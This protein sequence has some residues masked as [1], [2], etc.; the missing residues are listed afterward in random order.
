MPGIKTP[1]TVKDN[2]YFKFSNAESYKDLTIKKNQL[3]KDLINL[4]NS[5]IWNL[6]EKAE[7][8]D[9]KTKLNTIIIL[10]VSL[11]VFICLII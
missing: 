6:K 7:A 8:L 11:M 5:N 3:T 2:F 1:K 10:T 9:E 4:F